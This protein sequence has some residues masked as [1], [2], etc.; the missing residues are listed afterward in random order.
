MSLLHKMYMISNFFFSITFNFW[1]AAHASMLLVF[2]P[3][4]NF[5]DEVHIPFHNL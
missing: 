4:K 1:V 3:Y 2:S 5:T